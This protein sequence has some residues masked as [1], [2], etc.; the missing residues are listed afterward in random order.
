M[1]SSP[2]SRTLELLRDTGWVADVV[3]R[4]VPKTRVRR[5]LY[6]VIDVLAFHV[7]HSRILGVQATSG[8]N[9][10]ARTTKI[11]KEPRARGWLRAGGELEVW[12]WRRYVQ[13]DASPGST[14]ALWRPRVTTITLDSDWSLPGMI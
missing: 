6:G 4:W 7:E 12:A 1:A 3:E 11:L 8:P 2:T 9:G 13:P 5:D 14:G 10:A